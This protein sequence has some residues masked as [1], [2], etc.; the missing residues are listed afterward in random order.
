MSSRSGRKRGRRAAATTERPRAPKRAPVRPPDTGRGRRSNAGAARGYDLQ[1]ADA[2]DSEYHYGSDFG[3]DSEEVSEPEDQIESESESSPEPDPAS[4]S[5]FSLGGRASPGEVRRFLVRPPSPEPL[6]IQRDRPVPPLRLPD[7]SEDLL[8]PRDVALRVSAVYEILRRFRHPIRLSPFR[9]EDLCAAIACDEQSS[10][11]AEIHIA[12]LRALLR[13]EDSQQTH[14]GPI[15]HKDSVNIALYMLDV[16][17]WPEVL[18]AYVE[19]DKSFNR[20]ILLMLNSCEY[21]FTGFEER[22]KVL[23]FLCDQFLITN[24]I[25]EDLTS[26]VSIHY[27]DHCRVCHRLGD[28][29]CCET[30][31][32]VFHLECVDPPLVDVPSE[33]WQCALCK[34]HRLQGVTDCV[35]DVEKQGLLCRHEHL[36]F[37]RQGRKY[38]FLCR[39]IFVESEEGIVWY[40]STIP[41]FEELLFAIDSQNMENGLYRELMECKQEIVRQMEITDKITN[42]LKG[43][44]KSYIEVEN[45]IILRLQK[46]RNEKKTIENEGKNVDGDDL[47]S[48]E[49]DSE[50]I[51]VGCNSTIDAEGETVSPINTA[52]NSSKTTSNAENDKAS[53]GLEDARKRAEEKLEKRIED[54]DTQRLTRL[55]FSQISSGT[56]LFKLGNDTNFRTYVNQYTVNTLALN[57]PQRNEERDKKRHL[58]HK[59]SL[60]CAQEF[61]WVGLLNGTRSLLVNTLRQTLLQLEN[62]VSS[63]FMHPNWTLLRKPWLQAVQASLVPRDFARAIIVL[64]ACIKNVVFL[65]VWHEQLG[66]VRLQ[67]ITAA[68]R[69]ER[70]KIEKREKKEKEEEEERNKISFFVKYPISFKHQIWKQKGEEYRIHGQWGWLWHTATRKF[71]RYP[72]YKTGLSSGPQKIFAQVQIENAIKIIC[73]Q[74]KTYDFLS[75]ENTDDD[76]FDQVPYNIKALK[77]GIDHQFFEQIDI[78]KALTSPTRLLYPKVAKK[79][80]LDCLLARRIHFKILE[81]RQYDQNI[82]MPIKEDTMKE[83]EDQSVDVENDENE[84]LLSTNTIETNLPNKDDATNMTKEIQTLRQQYTETVQLAKGYKCYMKGCN[85]S[86]SA[87]QAPSFI[88]NCYSPLCI[89]KDKLRK[90]LLALIKKVHNSSNSN[91]SGK[92]LDLKTKSDLNAKNEILKDLTSAIA[93]AHNYDR[94]YLNEIVK[95]SEKIKVEMDSEQNCEVKTESKD[96]GHDSFEDCL[97]IKSEQVLEE[98]VIPAVGNEMELDQYICSENEIDLVGMA[99]TEKVVDN[100]ETERRSKRERK[101]RDVSIVKQ[102]NDEDADSDRPPIP[103]LRIST[104]GKSA[105]SQALAQSEVKVSNKPT[106]K[107]AFNR[108]FLLGKNYTKKEDR[109]IKTELAPDGSA[110][111]YSTTSTMGKVYLKKIPSPEKKKKRVTV[112]YPL[113][114]TFHTRSKAKSIMVLPAHELNRL[115]RNGGRLQVIGFNHNSKPNSCIWPYPCARPTFK[116]CW[117]YRTFSL[118]TLAAVSLQMRILW[119]CIRWDDMAT[120]PSNN[121]GKHQITT[122]T[123]II[124]LEMLK[125]RNIG[126]FL[127]KTQYLRRKVIIPL[128]VPKTVR[129]VTSIRSGLRK[130]KRAES[131]QSMEPQVTEEWVDEDKLELWEIKQYG[132]RVERAVPI[133]RTFTGKLPLTRSST[134][135][136]RDMAVNSTT[137]KVSAQ[138]IKDKMEQQ[139]RMQRAAHQQKRAQEM[140]QVAVQDGSIKLLNKNGTP[141]SGKSAL[142]SLLTSNSGTPTGNKTV[143]GTRRVFMTKGADGTTRV[144]AQP[145]TAQK[146]PTPS[147]QTSNQQQSLMKTQNNQTPKEGPQKVQIIRGPDGKITVRGLIPGQ[148]LLQMP[149]GKLHVIASGQTGNIPAG[150]QIIA[151]GGAA[152][153]PKIAVTSAIKPHAKLVSSTTAT[154]K[155]LASNS[156]PT[157]PTSKVIIRQNPVKTINAVG[158]DGQTP[159][160]NLKVVTQ[161][162][163]MIV[164][165]NQQVIV[166]SPQQVIV[167]G[168]V[169]MTPSP[170]VQVSQGTILQTNSRPLQTVV[171][172]GNSQIVQ[173]QVV[174]GGQIIQGQVVQSGQQVLQGST[175]VQGQVVRPA[176]TQLTTSNANSPQVINRAVNPG[177]QIVVNNPA[178]AQQLAAGKLQLATINGQQ[179]LIRPVGNN[180]AMIVAHITQQS[181]QNNSQSDATAQNQTIA[182]SQVQNVVVQQTMPSQAVVQNATAP[183]TSPVKQQCQVQVLSPPLANQQT[184]ALTEEQLMEQRLLVG[185]PP[186]TVIKTV[187]AQVV[188]FHGNPRIVLQGLQG[189]SLTQQQLALVQHQVKQQLLKAQETTGKEGV[190]GPTKLYLAV[191]PSQTVANS[192]IAHSSPPPLTNVRTPQHNQISQDQQ[193]KSIATLLQSSA[194]KKNLPSAILINGQD[195]SEPPAHIVLKPNAIISSKSSELNEKKSSELNVNS[196]TSSNKFVLTPDYIQQTIKNALKQDNLN[197]E[198]EE[199]LLQLQRYQEKQMKPENPSNGNGGTDSPNH[200]R[201]MANFGNSNSTSRRRPTSSNRNTD[202][203]EW[204]ESI[205]RKRNRSSAAHNERSETFDESRNVS[206]HRSRPSRSASQAPSQPNVPQNSLTSALIP[207]DERRRVHHLSRLP[208][209]LYR[210]KEILKKMIIKKRGLLEKELG[211]EIQKELSAELALRTKAERNKQDEVRSSNVNPTSGTSSR[212]RPQHS[213]NS[214]RQTPSGHSSS[215][216]RQRAKKEKLLC[217]CQTPYDDTKFYV[218]CEHCNNWF[219]GDCVGITEEMSK[220]I[221]EFVCSECK[222][223]RDTQELYC[224]CKQPYDNSQFY[225]CCDRCQDWFHGRC[226]GILQ[227]EADNIDEYICPNCQKNNSVNFANMKELSYKDFENLKKLIKQIQNHKSAWPFM[228][229]VDPREAPMYYKVIKEP[230][231]LQVIEKKINEQTYNMLSELIGDMTKIFDN[232]RYFNPKDSQFY[233]CAEGLEAFFVQKIKFFRE[234][235]FEANQ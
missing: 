72:N 152:P 171:M 101:I 223:A 13:E 76:F 230:M 227:S 45:S 33:D 58:A 192:T 151:T 191:Q 153:T 70:K 162:P 139:L 221:N 186:G 90:E 172:Q 51:V 100:S 136:Q 40:Y 94:K 109:P 62:S 64:Q 126:Q 96:S 144:I 80:R 23:E 214:T 130:R 175:V 167:Q 55:K 166:Q 121:D 138:E 228:E 21:P 118:S 10:L 78:Q 135:D 105:K 97:N 150:G 195:P 232:C 71:R 19:S 9:L 201:S 158:V 65:P 132:E 123:E 179:V 106:Y 79:S 160:S 157:T 146:T 41:Q 199:K 178:L 184:T 46:E 38:W 35:S 92:N 134:Q 73:V 206:S 122:E 168:Q 145:T 8:V 91:I 147:P 189:N 15:D 11:L 211:V 28:L 193:A 142:T 36:G 68:D 233:R 43:N 180:Q 176:T 217:I 49:V 3:D 69:E 114:S 140:S 164:Q 213:G 205:P 59:F 31:P 26:E 203:D 6:W 87:S 225:I 27:D 7:S 235:L 20:D 116:T 154:T 155:P 170:L 182:T 224:L 47:T 127:D 173:G 4:D 163:Q 110:R 174:Q 143:I 48:M 198:I 77:T 102:T 74:P 112:K 98:S 188:Q 196:P 54:L 216:S 226:V 148:Q 95:F 215:R 84:A 53:S 190:L 125:H 5:D 218:G 34:S 222:H 234:K 81:E 137:S 207:V 83:E 209:L 30:C 220:T 208:L 42:L 181:T 115:A 210:H 44:R 63:V 129:E 2:R 57:K 88:C 103:K 66:H 32:A 89:R 61:K 231:D 183:L 159:Q 107:A 17:T 187:T 111:V 52:E 149:D 120:K 50:A 165:G 12:L 56:L 212:R 133:T 141:Q 128:E 16:V 219:H 67:R 29:L 60:S 82:F 86:A 169:K 202:D 85:S 25:R 177:Q 197:P 204:I 194:N 200:T 131:P 37:D 113:C 185:Q 119:V 24:P 108:R 39:R 161:T 99:E 14:F 18:R 124:S 117:L 75:K 1:A 104:R 22:I 93:S 156:T 229:P